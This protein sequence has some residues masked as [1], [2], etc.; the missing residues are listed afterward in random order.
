MTDQLHHLAAAY[1]LDA[2]DGDERRAFEAHYPNCDI[3]SREVVEF[4]ETAAVLA[5]QAAALPTPEL[6]DRV[7]DEIARTRQLSPLLPESVA[8]LSARRRW[9]PIVLAGAAAAILVVGGVLAAVLSASRSDDLQEV[10]AAPDAVVSSLEGVEGS[11]QVV[12]SRDRDQVAVFG[13][14]L[15]APGPDLI[16]ELW[17]ILEDGVAPAGLFGPDG[18]TVRVVLDVDEVDG[19]GWGVTIE[20]AGGSESPTSDIVYLSGA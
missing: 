17:F 12:W 20:P 8:R 2:L 18:G 11:L 6:K 7:R 19:R 13:N 4:R 16:Y 15:P 14:D 10:L 1:A 9:R 5:E 3:C